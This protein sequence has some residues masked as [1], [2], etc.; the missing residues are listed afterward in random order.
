MRCG[1]ILFGAVTVLSCGSCGSAQHP[2]GPGWGWARRT[3]LVLSVGSFRGVAHLGVIQRLRETGTRVDCVV[4][5][6][7]GSLVGAIYASAPSEDTTERF[8]AFRAEYE[9]VT[10]A[11]G[12]RQS[13]GTGLF[14]GLLTLATGGT[15]A[16]ALGLG[17]TGA[18][19]G[20]A[21]FH[22]VH[23][24]RLVGV[25]QRQFRGARIEALP[26]AYATGYAERSRDGLDPHY[27]DRGDL[28]E[29]VGN[30]I[31]NPFIFRD[32]NVRRRRR[33]DPGGDREQAVPVDEACRRFPDARLIVINVTDHPSLR[34]AEMTCPVV[35]VRVPPTPYAD[36]VI[37]RGGAAFN[38]VVRAGYDATRTTL[39]DG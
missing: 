9:R 34:T 21:S 10:R 20:A 24:G 36:E 3:C 13:L 4:G 17:A 16:L 19:L 28:A 15:A 27:V 38:D 5:N 30:S 1:W 2:G 6:S 25:L 29:A 11:A 22:P 7:M 35:E 33:L 8:Q 18:A 23:H 37:A 39:R 12:E 31:A 32:V 14:V 26:V